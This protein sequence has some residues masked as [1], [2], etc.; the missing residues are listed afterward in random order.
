MKPF[1]L[2]RRRSSR[3]GSVSVVALIL[4][5]VGSLGLL[6]MVSIMQARVV[7]VESLEDACIRRV[8]EANG[9][10]MAKEFAFRRI[11]TSAAGAEETVELPGN[12]GRI[13]VPA[14][15]RA[16]FSTTTRAAVYNPTGPDPS[17]LPYQLSLSVSVF[18]RVNPATGSWETTSPK[19]VSTRIQSRALAN[20]GVLLDARSESSSSRTVGGNLTVRGRAMVWQ[21]EE[22]NHHFSFDAEQLSG[23]SRSVSQSNVTLQNANGA[24]A[25][26]P[27]NFPGLTFPNWFA[28]AG[29]ALA[30]GSY[31]VFFADH[32]SPFSSNPIAPS[33]AERAV[34]LGAIT[35][36]GGVPY[37]QYGATSNEAGLMTVDLNSLN[38]P[39]LIL[40]NPLSVVINGQASPDA[41]MAVENLAPILIV[42]RSTATTSVS[43]LGN[44]SR[45][46][47]VAFQ[48]N[49]SSTLALLFEGGAS[50]RMY[51]LSE[52]QP[53][54]LSS[55][56]ATILRGGI[57]TDDDFVV[58][59]GSFE[60]VA[61]TANPQW[62]DQ[63]LWR[64]FW[65]ETYD[66]L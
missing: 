17:G 14:W 25:L 39:S 6:G 46:L 2:H 7:Q 49:D 36:Q 33:L 63:L 64:S 21:P 13:T 40:E 3:T 27:L 57:A 19:L 55:T 59:A 66:Q 11:W 20:A 58:A 47:I 5:A 24:G 18:N 29:S 38:L 43:F 22:V 31:P 62:F 9:R 4:C 34:A 12:W 1:L 60:V 8:R 30:P 45:P 44:N 32:W 48:S 42:L 65:V 15:D 35:L 51:L 61:E 23:Y 37:D 50:Y 28:P 53:L 26:R 41:Q 16:A 56:G 54:S 52:Q 10:Q